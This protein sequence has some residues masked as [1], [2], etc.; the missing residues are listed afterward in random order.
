MKKVY[1]ANWKMNK[2]I[3]EAESFMKEFLPMV[4]DNEN[5]IIMCAN[6]LCLPKMQEMVNNS[7]V[8]IAGQ[9]IYPEDAG[10]FTG[11]ISLPMLAELGISNIMLGHSERRIYFG[12]TDEFI[13]KKIKKAL[14]AGF[15]IVFC[16]GEKEEERNDKQ[17]IGVLTRQLKIGLADVTEEQMSHVYV[18]YEPI[19]SISTFSTGRIATTE[20]IFEVHNQIKDILKE[21]FPNV[22][23]NILV[24]YGGSVSPKNKNEIMALSNV[25]GAL[26]G[27]A[28]LKPESL[29][30]V[31]K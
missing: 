13:N 27:G 28:S 17:T 18:A 12:E 15:D 11:E 24:L 20:E 16:I 19:W 14:E 4:E 23:E 21:M 6:A 30:E 1:V 8:Q 3:S 22:W 26:I 10:A 2:T 25:D 5:K 31:V 9:N 7:N 29:A